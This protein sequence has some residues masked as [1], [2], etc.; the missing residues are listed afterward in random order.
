MN[1]K[2]SIKMEQTFRSIFPL[3]GSNR[4]VRCREPSTNFVP[5]ECFLNFKSFYLRVFVKKFPEVSL[6][7]SVWESEALWRNMNKF[8]NLFNSVRYKQL[9]YLILDRVET[10]NWQMQK[11]SY[12]ILKFQFWI[13]IL[14]RR[15]IFRRQHWI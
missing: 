12:M 10:I 8:M 11:S 1:K 15:I 6:S 4:I 7:N 13:I 5:F 9:S 2:D 14:N 3:F